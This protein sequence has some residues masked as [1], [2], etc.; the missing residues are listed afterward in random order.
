MRIS[1]CVMYFQSGRGRFGI[2]TPKRRHE[3]LP[4]LAPQ[5]EPPL[6]QGSR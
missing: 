5:R 2:E 6:S 4:K 3:K 1:V